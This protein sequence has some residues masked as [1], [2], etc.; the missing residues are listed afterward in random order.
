[1]PEPSQSLRAVERGFAVLSAL[2]DPTDPLS[3][4]QVSA[5]VGFSRAAVRRVLL[6]LCELGYVT[7]SKPGH[8]APRA[9][10][11]RLG[12]RTLALRSL[13][14]LARPVLEELCERTG[15]IAVL[16]RR[17]GVEIIVEAAMVPRDRN[18][19]HV[20]AG[21][22]LPPMT[23]DAGRLLYSNEDLRDPVVESL[24]RG[25][26]ETAARFRAAVE[27]AETEGYCLVD[28]EM[29][30]GLVS[31]GVPVRGREGSIPAALSLYAYAGTM[32]AAALLDHLPVLAEGSARLESDLLRGAAAFALQ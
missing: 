32:T 20:S 19:F 9:N 4:S 25:S 22:R 29:E 1:M 13:A 10:V 5:K 28:Q 14:D 3:V 8:Y 12:W 30:P 18:V 11:L 27:T 16:S 23:S 15:H 17:L 24:L 7:E 31:L 2:A 6:T 26:G 21:D